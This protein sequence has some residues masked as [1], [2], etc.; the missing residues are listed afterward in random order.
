MTAAIFCYSRTGIETAKRVK[1][2]LPDTDAVLYTMERFAEPGFLPLQKSVYGLEFSRRDALIFVGAAGIAVREI[3]P[4]VRDKKTDPAVLSIDERANFVIPLLSGHI[5]GANRLAVMLANALGAVA[6][7]TTATD[8]NGKFA[9]DEFAAR[10]G[11]AISDMQLAKS[12]AAAILERDL[13]LQSAFPIISSLPGGV[14]PGD[15]G[16]LGVYI[17]CD[18]KTPFEKTLRLVPRKLRVGIGCRRGTPEEAIEAA[19]RDVFAENRLDL[20]A[21]SGVFSIDLKKNEAGLL[22]ACRKNG[23]PVRFY[24]AE[25]LRAVPGDFTRSEFVSSVTGVD[26]VC[27]RAAL[28]GAQTL[29]VRKT[30]LRGV[31]VAA[32]LEHW[33]VDFG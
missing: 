20:R 6:V 7:I 9:V 1:A 32:A 30:A 2:L 23:W 24:S 4:F 16:D 17:G 8:V 18:V 5:G 26:N 11:C 25:Q 13:P 10:N 21:I 12:F 19:I 29:L 15:T 31:T 28:L 14:I 22:A 33:E 27:E 3:A